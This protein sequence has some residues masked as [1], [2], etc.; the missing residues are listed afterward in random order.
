MPLGDGVDASPQRKETNVSHRFE[1]TSIG[2]VIERFMVTP[3]GG[4]MWRDKD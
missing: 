1:I 3:T 2:A 4:A